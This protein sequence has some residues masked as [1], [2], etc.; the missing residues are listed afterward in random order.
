[1]DI[2]IFL[3]YLAITLLAGFTFGK[4]AE[5][6]KIPAITGYIIAGVF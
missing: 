6:A 5:F 2:Y 3:F 1:M 4:L